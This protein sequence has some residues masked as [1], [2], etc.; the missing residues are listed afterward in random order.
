MRLPTGSDQTGSALRR[1]VPVIGLTVTVIAGIALGLLMVFMAVSAPASPQAADTGHGHDDAAAAPHGHSDAGTVAMPGLEPSQQAA[2]SDT[3]TADMSGMSAADMAAMAPAQPAAESMAGM[4]AAEMAAMSQPTPA[5]TAADP[6]AGMSA[7]DMAAMTASEP[8]AADSSRPLAA[9]LA[10]FVLLNLS[11][12]I[13][14][15]VLGRR[16]RAHPEAKAKE[17]RRREAPRSGRAG[18]PSV[19]GTAPVQSAN[20]SATES[21]GSPS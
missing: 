17:P 13:A 1:A 8:A 9:T 3:G 20:E 18:T 5:P 11:V 16:R 12:L 2:G 21:A 6:M 15:V 10:G 14:A 7:A 19:P 4:S